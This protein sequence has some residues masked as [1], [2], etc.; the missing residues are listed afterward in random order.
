MAVIDQVMSDRYAIYNADNMEVLPGLK[1]ASI[2]F[3]VYSP[4]F[5]ELYAYSNSPRDMSNCVRYEEGLDQYEYTVKEIFRLTKAGRETAVHCMDLKKGSLYQRDFPGDIVRLHEKHGWN[6]FCRVT[7]RKDPWLI[8][9]RTRMKSLMHKTLVNDSSKSRMAGPDYIL[10]FRKGGEN[11]E[12]I[13]HPYGLKHY[14]G[15]RKPPAH[16]ISRFKNFKGDQKKNLL[17][18]WIWRRYAD[19]VWDDIRTGRLLPYKESRENEDEKHVCPLQLD[20]LERLMVLYSRPDDIILE[21]Y[22]GVGS[23]V[24]AALQYGRKA[25]GVE[26]KSTYFRQSKFNIEETLKNPWYGDESDLFSRINSD[27]EIVDDDVEMDY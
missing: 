4:P 17:S 18:H 3:S 25:I 5:P 13:N 20:I 11:E 24:C 19:N 26:L 14:A 6:Y 21:P 27:E 15:E 23:T 7:I 22:M 2:G 9:R 10:I 8:A 16:L 12:P 1:P